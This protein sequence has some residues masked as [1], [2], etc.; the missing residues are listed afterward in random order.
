MP[1]HGPGAGRDAVDALVA[2]GRA[3]GLDAVGVAPAGAFAGTRAT[4]EARRAAGLHAG[5]QFTYR[6]PAR[7]TDPARALAGAGALVVG[8]RSYRRTEVGA[9]PALATS[10]TG[11]V[12]RYSWVDH[13][14]PLRAG[15][16]AVAEHLRERGWQARVLADDN[17]LVDREAAFRAGLGWYGKNTN[18]L[19][20]GRGS[21]FVLGA[22]VTDAPLPSA[23]PT[24]DPAEAA[25]AGCGP[26]SRCQVACPTG[27]LDVAGVLDA[28]RCLAWLLQTDGPFPPEHRI[29]LGARLYGCDD[30]QDVCPPNRLEIRR[31]PPPEAEHDAEPA[32]DVLELLEEDDDDVLLARHGRWYIARRQA[33]HLRRNA[34]VVLGN[35]GDGADDR[36]VAVLRRHLGPSADPLVR[37]HAVWAAARLG[38]ADLLAPLHEEPSPNP[39]V[40][41]ELGALPTPR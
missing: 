8:A 18:L 33:R 12:A 29:A 4:L 26:C 24:V 1:H 2:V 11:R 10:A 27:A 6:N 21:E 22:V 5:M 13:Y 20:H 14:V 35:V 28:N 32:V 39:L 30:C 25:A 3:A 31:R 38:R 15:L 16:E 9:D 36:T 41:A 19:L 7:S 23:E 17:A 34:L 37:G 40:A